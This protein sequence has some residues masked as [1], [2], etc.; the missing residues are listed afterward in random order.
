MAD[1]QYVVWIRDHRLQPDDQ[2]YEW[3]ACFVVA[4]DNEREAL[5]WG[6]QLAWDYT[7]RH[8]EYEALRSYLNSD[9]WPR[10]VLPKVVAG[11]LVP[12]EV[13]GW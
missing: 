6:D 4:S 8:A 3:P 7:R 9:P 5:A 10:G 12:D 2:D 1:Y 11:E 13:I